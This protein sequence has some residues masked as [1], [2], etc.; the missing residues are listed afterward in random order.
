MKEFRKYFKILLKCSRNRDTWYSGKDILG[1]AYRIDEDLKCTNLEYVVP[2]VTE[3]VNCVE[4]NELSFLCKL[5]P[6]AHS[7]SSSH[8]PEF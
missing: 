1:Q 6:R 7:S 8:R 4:L 5:L 3:Q 2:F